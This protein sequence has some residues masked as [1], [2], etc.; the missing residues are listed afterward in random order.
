LIII[1]IIRKLFLRR[2]RCYNSRTPNPWWSTTTSSTRELRKSVPVTRR[3][4][5]L[6]LLRFS[7]GK[8]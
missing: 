5:Q 7:G 6:W 1:N 2:N 4:Y 8:Y 3:C